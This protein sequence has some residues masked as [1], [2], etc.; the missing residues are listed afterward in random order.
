[1]YQAA[2][3][4]QVIISTA[5]SLVYHTRVLYSGVLFVCLFF[6]LF[7]LDYCMIIVCRPYIVPTYSTSTSAGGVEIWAPPHPPIHHLQYS[8]MVSII[9]GVKPIRERAFNLWRMTDGFLRLESTQ[10]FMGGEYFIQFL[11]SNTYIIILSPS[12]FVLIFIF[13]LRLFLHD[14]IQIV[15]IFN[16]I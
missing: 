3:R 12:F 4:L 8:S 11:N 14:T 13:L 1:M 7:E 15:N 6:V 10:I 2:G 5:C 9:G 16:V